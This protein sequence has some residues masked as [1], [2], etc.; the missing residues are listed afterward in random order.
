MERIL[1]EMGFHRNSDWRYVKLS[2]TLY[3]FVIFDKLPIQSNKL[4]KPKTTLWW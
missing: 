2:N 3:D 1:L 4:K